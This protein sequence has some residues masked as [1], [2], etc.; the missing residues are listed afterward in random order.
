LENRGRELYDLRD[1]PGE[2]MNLV[3][4]RPDIAKRLE[5]KLF[6]HYGSI[7]HDLGTKRWEIGLNPVYSSQAKD[8][9][10]K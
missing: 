5:E 3:E 9:P 2:I 7:G 6:D 8:P 1:D 4:T 10:K